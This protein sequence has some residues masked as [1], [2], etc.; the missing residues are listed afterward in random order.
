MIVT[1]KRVRCLLF[2]S[3]FL[4]SLFLLHTRIHISVS[5]HAHAH[6]SSEAFAA[7]SPLPKPHSGARKKPALSVKGRDFTWPANRFHSLPALAPP[8]LSVC[9]FYGTTVRDN[10]HRHSLPRRE[11]LMRPVLGQLGWRQGLHHPRRHFALEQRVL[12]L[13]RFILRCIRLSCS[14]RCGARSPLSLPDRSCSPLM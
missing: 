10:R 1:V 2:R 4:F 14:A 8:S 6:T 5:P 3:F 9:G 11:Q 13:S 7:L 12:H